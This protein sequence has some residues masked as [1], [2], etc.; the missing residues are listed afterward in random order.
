MDYL[1]LRKNKSIFDKQYKR[2]KSWLKPKYKQ[3]KNIYGGN[4]QF[5]KLNV[6]FN[7]D[8]DV[9]VNTYNQQGG[10]K[11]EYI[12]L[13]SLQGFKGGN[14]HP[15]NETVDPAPIEEA[16][17]PAPDPAPIEDAPSDPTAPIPIEEAP[18]AAPDPVVD[19]NVSEVVPVPLVE[20]KCDEKPI[21]RKTYTIPSGSILYHGSVELETFNTKPLIVGSKTYTTFFTFSEELAALEFGNCRPEPGKG[22]LHKFEVIKSINNVILSELYSQNYVGENGV[23]MAYDLDNINN[24][25]CGNYINQFGQTFDAVAFKKQPDDS[26]LS[27]TNLTDHPDIENIKVAI[28]K[29]HEFLV[30]KSSRRCQYGK[31]SGDYNFTEN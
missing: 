20:S 14:N 25:Y 19:E 11:Y 24:N 2:R 26:E 6:D 10:Q 15:E 12:T 4:M 30:Y 5:I 13:Q 21:A 22:Y 9:E 28:C 3:Q 23:S 29:P 27:I 7:V 18:T 31:L 16:S 17:T 1:L 8:T